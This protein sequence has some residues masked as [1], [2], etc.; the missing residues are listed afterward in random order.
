MQRAKERNVRKW[1]KTWMIEKEAGLDTTTSA[2]RLKN[3]RKSLSEF[4][5]PPVALWTVPVLPPGIPPSSPAS[6]LATAR[7]PLQIGM[8]K[9]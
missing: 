1:K 5:R 9:K 3:A 4:P 2:I 6:G 8:L 7:L